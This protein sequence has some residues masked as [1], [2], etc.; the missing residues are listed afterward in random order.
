MKHAPWW[1]LYGVLFFVLYPLDLRA[2][3]VE[4]VPPGEDRIEVL[5]K[6]EVSPFT[7]Q[8][9][10]QD[11]ALRWRNWLGQYRLRLR[12]SETYAERRLALEIDF[13]Q[14]ELERTKKF[15]EEVVGLHIQRQREL[16]TQ[17]RQLDAQT[18]T[19]PAWYSSPWFAFST[20]L[21]IGTA[22]ALTLR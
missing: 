17:L 20:G 7:G 6:G 16:E 13:S 9:F 14:R 19:P 18:R 11:T 10:D 3:G 8:L 15:H 1:K 5:R 2:Q 12:E 4:A 22:L 21:V